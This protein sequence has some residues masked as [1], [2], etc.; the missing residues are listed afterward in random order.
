MENT[1]ESTLIKS[2]NYKD[3]F[4]AEYRQLKYRYDKLRAFNNRIA[5]ANMTLHQAP[6]INMPKHDCP[7]F[8]LEDQERVME[9]YLRILEKRAIIEGIELQEAVEE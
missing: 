9:S 4:I 8:L 3:R 5:A 1:L 6:R 2:D 7:E